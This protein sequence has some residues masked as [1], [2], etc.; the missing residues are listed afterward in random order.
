MS[1][2][3]RVRIFLIF[4]FAVAAAMFAMAAYLFPLPFSGLPSDRGTLQTTLSTPVSRQGVSPQPSMEIFD[5]APGSREEQAAENILSHYQVH[6]C[7]HTL[8]GLEEWE[9]PAF[10]IH[11]SKFSLAVADGCH[12]YLNG[13]LYRVGWLGEYRGRKLAD[14]L[15]WAL[16]LKK[17]QCSM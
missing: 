13:T 1:L 16:G 6:R 2:R 7:L 10:L 4:L 17:E 8:T 3:Q 14:E 9:K 5:L 11:T 12:V 15:S